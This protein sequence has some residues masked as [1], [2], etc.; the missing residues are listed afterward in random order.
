M[1][2]HEFPKLF[3]SSAGG[4]SDNEVIN[5]LRIFCFVDKVMALMDCCHFV[6]HFASN[7]GKQKK[8]I[9]IGI[10]LSFRIQCSHFIINKRLCTKSCNF[11]NS[12]V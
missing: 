6:I 12:S 4:I 11:A 5:S 2:P 9:E 7:K 8:L 10:E 1:A 3:L